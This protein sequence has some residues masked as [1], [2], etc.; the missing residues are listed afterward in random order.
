MQRTRTAIKAGVS[1]GNACHEHY[2]GDEGGHAVQTIFRQCSSKNAFLQICLIPRHNR[3]Q[4]RNRNNIQRNYTPGNITYSYRNALFR[5]FAFAGSQTDD[6]RT[7]EVN[8]ND[9]HRQDNRPIAHRCKA[10]LRKQDA[11]TQITLSTNKAKNNQTSNATEGYQ[12]GDFDNG[13]P[14]FAFAKIINMEKIDNRHQQTEKNR[15]PHLAHR[16]HKVIHDNTCSNHFR[17][18]V[19]HPVKPIGPAHA[20]RPG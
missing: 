3:K 17:G 15:P 1:A 20:T 2:K 4:Q 8:Q 7:L 6:F 14:K 5:V 16:R 13:K 19:G 10:S 12:S 18:N 9:N 11:R